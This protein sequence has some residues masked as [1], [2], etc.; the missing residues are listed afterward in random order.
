MHPV[1]LGA[2]D[3]TV[4]VVQDGDGIETVNVS[5]AAPTQPGETPVVAWYEP[6]PR[7]DRRLDAN[8]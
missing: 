3:P 5:F 6:L 8:R 2:V 1:V 4:S 7:G